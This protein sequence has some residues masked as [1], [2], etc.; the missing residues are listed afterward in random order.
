MAGRETRGRKKAKLNPAG[1]DAAL[2]GLPS[3]DAP[4]ILL[5]PSLLPEPER[6][7]VTEPAENPDEI[8]DI[9][10]PVPVRKRVGKEALNQEVPSTSEQPLDTSSDDVV[11]GKGLG[12]AGKG[13]KGGL[14]KDQ[15][16]RTG[17]NAAT[18]GGAAGTRSRRGDKGFGG[19]APGQSM[20]CAGTDWSRGLELL[21]S[22]ACGVVSGRLHLFAGLPAK[23]L[24]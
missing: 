19:A 10:T 18:G 11:V 1:E 13:A 21:V 14:R 3:L 8:V 4:E 12:P 9:G 20:P 22:Q 2:A 7:H 23:T 16:G 5:E 15:V 17:R 6:L 24:L